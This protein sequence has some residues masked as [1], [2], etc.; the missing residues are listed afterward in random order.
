MKVCVLVQDLLCHLI[1]MVVLDDLKVKLTTDEL[2]MRLQF[3]IKD[4]FLDFSAEH[5]GSHLLHAEF[6][7][8]RLA[9]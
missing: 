6:L 8:S 9:E 3:L 2:N 1:L 5:H 4:P 7:M